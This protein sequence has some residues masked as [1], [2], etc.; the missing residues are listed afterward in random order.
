MNRPDII[1]RLRENEGP[2]RERGIRHAALFGSCARGEER[3]D[4]DI[5]IMIEVDPAARIG[6]Y[7]YVAIKDYIAGLFD[8]RVDVVRHDRLKSYVG[9]AAAEDAIYAF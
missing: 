8:T 7:E 4:S 1:A 5:D 6:V 3:P 9:P 2:L